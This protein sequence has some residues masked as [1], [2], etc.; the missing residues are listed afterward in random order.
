MRLV[1]ISLMFSIAGIAA[2]NAQN[3]PLPPNTLSCQGFSKLQNGDWHAAPNAQPFDV[4][5]MTNMHITNLDIAPHA[6]NMGGT[7]LWQLIEQ[8]CGST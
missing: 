7:D 8:K 5:N 3:K 2:G 4:G 6:F 1:A